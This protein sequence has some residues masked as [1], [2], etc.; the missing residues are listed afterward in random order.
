VIS[1]DRDFLDSFFVAGQP[2]RLLWVTNGLLRWWSL[3]EIKV[4][5]AMFFG[6][7]KAITKLEHVVLVGTRFFMIE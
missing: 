5:I 3:E 1:K 7:F 2:S 4:A 6:V